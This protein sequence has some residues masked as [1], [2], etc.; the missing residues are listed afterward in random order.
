MAGKDLEFEIKRED[1]KFL[2]GIRAP[3]PGR[4][5]LAVSDTHYVEKRSALRMVEIFE[6]CGARVVIDDQTEG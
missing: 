3:H 4:Q 6:E 5:L 2:V 1:G